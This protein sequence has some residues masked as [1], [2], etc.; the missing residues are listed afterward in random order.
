M[1]N[2]VS[3]FFIAAKTNM[4]PKAR[5][6]PRLAN[7]GSFIDQNIPQPVVQAFAPV[8]R[9]D[10]IAAG[11]PLPDIQRLCPG[12]VAGRKQERADEQ[13]RASSGEAN[14]LGE[15]ATLPAWT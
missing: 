5:R 14:G 10:D 9:V 3:A 7:W 12:L 2:S 6:W 1:G 8:V 15:A 11:I 4:W 13:L